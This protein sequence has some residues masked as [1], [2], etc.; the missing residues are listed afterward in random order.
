[1]VFDVNVAATGEAEF[2]LF[3]LIAQ[4]SNLNHNQPIL[5]LRPRSI[6]NVLTEITDPSLAALPR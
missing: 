2:E 3:R 6:D 5:G 1:M 4:L